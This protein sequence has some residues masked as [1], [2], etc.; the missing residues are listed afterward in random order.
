MSDA[1]APL[2]RP[3]APRGC[4]TPAVVYS[5][6]YP[7]VA[8]ACRKCGYAAALHG[9]MAHDLDIMAVPWT[10]EATDIDTLIVAVHSAIYGKTDAYKFEPP[11]DKPHGRKS[12]TFALHNGAWIDFSVMPRRVAL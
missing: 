8:R 12:W 5:F 4:R 6:L 7:D 3:M 9:T 10:D 2:L 11:S 1:P